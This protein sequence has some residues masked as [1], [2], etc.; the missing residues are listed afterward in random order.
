MSAEGINTSISF[1]VLVGA[2]DLWDI[3]AQCDET[4][5]EVGSL[6]LE[7]TPS[8]SCKLAA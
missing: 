5:K 7:E 6:T 3:E 2:S 8:P 4:T 1:L